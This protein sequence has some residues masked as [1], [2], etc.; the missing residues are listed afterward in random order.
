MLLCQPIALYWEQGR[1]DLR[2]AAEEACRLLTQFQASSGEEFVPP[3]LDRP[4]EV[5]V[6]QEPPADLLESVCQLLRKGAYRVLPERF[7]ALLSFHQVWSTQLAQFARQYPG[8]KD[9]LELA[10]SDLRDYQDAVGAL[11]EEAWTDA[12][13]MF[14]QVAAN[15]RVRSAAM[16][17]VR[18][19]EGFSP[20]AEVDELAWHLQRGN[21]DARAVLHKLQEAELEVSAVLQQKFPDPR[22]RSEWLDLWAPLCKELRQRFAVRP[23]LALMPRLVEFFQRQAHW[24]QRARQRRDFGRL[25]WWQQLREDLAGWFFGW[26]LRE[27]VRLERAM[28]WLNLD[29]S[30]WPEADRELREH[31]RQLTIGWLGRVECCLAASGRHQVSELVAFGDLHFDRWLWLQSKA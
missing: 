13:P 19:L 22:L 8:K 20:I 15:L 21:P 27:T 26:K 6:L 10:Q 3:D 23:D 16:G 12:G 14:S 25:P 2:P 7:P 11:V 30:A 9:L 29:F 28:H 1:P 18:R 5:P 17:E 24:L 4:C 31:Y